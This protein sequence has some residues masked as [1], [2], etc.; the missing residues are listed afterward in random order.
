MGP[1]RPF[2]DSCPESQKIWVPFLGPPLESRPES[3][4]KWVPSETLFG[5]PLTSLSL[6]TLKETYER[7]ISKF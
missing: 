2:T 3:Q 5:S 6:N 7:K 4:K 1:I